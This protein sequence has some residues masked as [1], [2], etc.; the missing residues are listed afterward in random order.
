MVWKTPKEVLRKLRYGADLQCMAVFFQVVWEGIYMA[1]EDGKVGSGA[2]KWN[3]LLKIQC[4]K[5]FYGHQVIKCVSLKRSYFLPVSDTRN[6]CR[7]QKELNQIN[8]QEQKFAVAGLMVQQ[9]QNR[10]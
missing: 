1:P 5:N 7:A 2:A 4:G 8:H 9:H 10:I 6:L 3:Q